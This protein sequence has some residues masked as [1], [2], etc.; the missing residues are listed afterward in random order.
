M[1]LAASGAIS[2]ADLRTE[3]VGGSSSISLGDLY[4]GGSN[5]KTKEGDNP[6]TNM[7][8]SVPTSGT[9]DLADFHGTAKGFKATISSS[10]TNVDVDTLFGGDYDTDYPKVVAINAGVTIG[11]TGGTAAMTIASN[12]A[13]SL[14]IEN[15][16]SVIGTGGSA[17]GGDGGHA[18]SNSASGVTITNTG[19]LAAGGGGG[20]QG[21]NGGGG[22]AS[23]TTSY[24]WNWNREWRIRWGPYSYPA[25][26]DIWDGGSGYAYSFYYGNLTNVTSYLN[27]Q[28]GAYFDQNID[29]FSGQVTYKRYALTVT[30]TTNTNGG[31]G[32]AGGRGQ[33]YNQTLESGSS[34]ASGGTNAGAGGSGASGAVYGTAG[35]TGSTGANGNSTNGS[36]GSSGGAAGAAVSGTS[37]TMNNTGTLHGAVA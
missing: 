11:G 22:Q 10:T 25:F 30:S 32:G 28:R 4:R 13:G 27:Y 36:A 9:I 16:G 24:S 20:G 2:L 1:T 6:A 23:T 29:P 3:Y 26:L 18:I 5:I 12:I 21:G 31:S 7:A 33:G 17:N 15:A 14:T 34:G 8:A 19:L 37:V 35:S